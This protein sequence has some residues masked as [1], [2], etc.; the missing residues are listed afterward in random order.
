[1]SLIVGRTY[2]ARA[3]RA[4]SFVRAAAA[5]AATCWRPDALS[6]VVH[7]DITARYLQEPSSIHGTRASLRVWFLGV[8]F[9]ARH[10]RGLSTLQFQKG[11]GLG[12][13]QTAWTLLHKLRSGLSALPTP[14]LEGDIEADET[15]IGGYRKGWNGRGAGKVGVAIAIPGRSRVAPS[16]LSCQNDTY[17]L[18]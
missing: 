12:S 13:Y 3:S 14:L 1:M 16:G 2:A 17:R 15:Y 11:T 18:C 9:L 4:V 5:A 7:V 6:S 10:Q 8:F